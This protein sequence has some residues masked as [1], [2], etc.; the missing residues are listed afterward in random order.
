MNA[1]NDFAEVRPEMANVTCHEVSCPS[2]DSSD[3]NRSLFIFIGRDELHNY[4]CPRTFI[5][6][7]VLPAGI[8]GLQKF[9]L[10]D[11]SLQ[12]VEGQNC[13]FARIQAPQAK[14]RARR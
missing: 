1:L 9:R 10:A 13:I 14:V 11:I 12:I 8:V 4:I 3:Q 7:D 5:E 2:F 6:L